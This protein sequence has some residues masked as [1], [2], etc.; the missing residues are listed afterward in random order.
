M[1]TIQIDD[2]LWYL[3]GLSANPPTKAHESIIKRISELNVDLTVIPSYKHPV[4]TNLIDYDRRVHMVRLICEPFERVCVSTIERDIGLNSTYEVVN[5]MRSRIALFERTTFVVV[6]DFVIMTDTLDLKRAHSLELLEADDVAFCVILNGTN[7]IE[8]DKRTIL[9]HENCKN[10]NISFLVIDTI[11]DNIRSTN[12]RN[13][14]DVYEGLVPEKVYR[15]IR[16]NGITF[17]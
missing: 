10:S 13:D 8:N 7:D 11:D 2:T 1:E 3:Y 4:K 16:D 6:C 17:V 5:C 14:P 9:E 12:F 15:Y